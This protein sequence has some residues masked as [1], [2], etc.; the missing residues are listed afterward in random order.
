[1]LSDRLDVLVEAL[2]VRYSRC[3]VRSSDWSLAQIEVAG[4]R[5][6]FVAKFAL[7]SYI[8]D[9]DLLVQEAHHHAFS[10]RKSLDGMDLLRLTASHHRVTSI[11]EFADIASNVPLQD[12]SAAGMVVLVAGYIQ[13]QVV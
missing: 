3:C 1:M 13:N 5:I 7:N 9:R 4:G 2:E 8:V 10:D 12:E 6:N 11:E